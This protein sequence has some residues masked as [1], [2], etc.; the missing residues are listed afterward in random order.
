M[1]QSARA[2]SVRAARPGPVGL[3][4][5]HPWRR[6]RTR[7]AAIPRTFRRRLIRAAAIIV[8]IDEPVPPG[9]AP[10]FENLSNQWTEAGGT[11][12]GFSYARIGNSHGGGRPKR[13]RENHAA[14]S[15]GRNGFSDIGRGAYR[16][17]RHR[18]TKRRRTDGAAANAYRICVSILS[19]TTGADGPGECRTAV[20]AGRRH[21]S[22]QRRARSSRMGGTRG[23]GG[24]VSVPAL[25]WPDAASGDCARAGTYA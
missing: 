12:R 1:G 19:T 15:S 14:E 17:P 13:L 20:A 6:W 22:A 11:A 2:V 25:R 10:G 8:C 9:I 16:R 7:E 4:P 3:L 21:R 24:F 5:D 23:K 18:F